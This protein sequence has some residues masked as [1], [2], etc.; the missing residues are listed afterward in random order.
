[1]APLVVPDKYTEVPAAMPPGPPR[2]VG[3]LYLRMARAIRG[4]TA[5]EPDFDVAVARHRLIDAIQRSSDDGKVIR[6]GG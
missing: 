6:L 5:V 2:N 3:H 1:M 4:N